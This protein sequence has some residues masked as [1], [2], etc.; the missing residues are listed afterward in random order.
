[1]YNLKIKPD[2]EKT[3]K[4]QGKKNR[5]QVEIILKKIDEILEN[6]HIYNFFF[7]RI[8][9][10]KKRFFWILFPYTSMNI[11]FPKVTIPRT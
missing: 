1:M 4:K 3:L 11:P 7:L 5:K 9:D 8:Q 6:P 2:L 10:L